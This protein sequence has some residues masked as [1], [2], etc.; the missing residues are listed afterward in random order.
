MSNQA[1]LAVRFRP[2]DPFFARLPA[3]SLS[4]SSGAARGGPVC[5]SSQYDMG[6]GRQEHRS[7]MPDRLADLLFVRRRRFERFPKG[8]AMGVPRAII[9][10]ADPPLHTRTRAV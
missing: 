9:L 2:A 4:A 10:E 7:A 3:R 5:G 8:A 6:N 1:T